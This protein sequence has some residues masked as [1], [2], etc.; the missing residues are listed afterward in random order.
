MMTTMAEPP[1]H[2]ATVARLHRVMVVERVRRI[3]R[4][5]PKMMVSSSRPR[6]MA[7]S[8]RAAAVV[9]DS[10]PIA[11]SRRGARQK[12]RRAMVSLRRGVLALA[13]RTRRIPRI[14]LGDPWTDVDVDDEM[15]ALTVN[16]KIFVS[17]LG[18]IS[19]ML[20][21]AC[22]LLTCGRV[23][24]AADIRVDKLSGDDARDGSSWAA[25][26]SSISRALVLAQTAAGADTIHVAAGT[27][28]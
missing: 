28:P 11:R 4:S 17:S 6:A 7:I 12:S 15:K 13:D 19:V 21:L 18:R 20:S 1:S 24:R 23:A 2:R 5:R 3:A 16:S 27:Y 22:C 9:A 26:V 14:A 25:A 10:R 8:P